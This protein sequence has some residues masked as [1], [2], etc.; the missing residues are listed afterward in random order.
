M[1]FQNLKILSYFILLFSLL[2][3]TFCIS[4]QKVRAEGASLYFS[5]ASG[6]FLIGST[7]DVS[8]FVN[9]NGNNINAV[10]VNIKFDPKKIQVANPTAGK[11]FIEAWVS[12][13]T[14]SN[15]KGTMSFT[16]GVP[17][18]GINASAGLVSTVTFRAISPGQT[19]IFFSDSSAHLDDGK[20]TD[21]LT[22]TG[23]GVYT[24]LIPPPEGPKVFSFTHPDQNKWYNNNNPTFSWEKEEGVTDFSYSLDHSSYGVPDNISEGDSISVSYTDLEDGI[25]Y[26]NVKA[27]KA[28]SWGGTS[29]YLVQIDTT[30][31][32]DFPLVFEPPLMSPRLIS[33]NPIITFITTDA[34]SGISHYELKTVDFTKVD[35]KAEVGF[36]IEIASPYKLPLPNFGE[37]EVI[38]RVYDRAGNWRD[39]SE[40]IEAIAPEKAFFVTESGVNVF[41]IFL[42]WW[43]AMFILTLL[44]SVILALVFRWRKSH[45]RFE[46]RRRALRE[47]KEKAEKNGADVKK[48]LEETKPI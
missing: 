37:Y 4:I 25:W 40:K 42:S 17:S 11:S 21:I 35:E 8:V 32:A 38:V 14:Y 3:F 28:E 29:H 23:R 1:K 24:L 46:Q 10:K 26:F 44:I 12:Q 6:A 7:F 22:S 19:S 27:K 47:I 9:T 20:G 18:P 13:P 45:Q 31:P 16:G 2:I 33:K 30:S 48:K 39:V 41:G 36:F 5:P 34:L 43:R 15:I